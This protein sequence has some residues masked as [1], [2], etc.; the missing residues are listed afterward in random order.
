MFVSVF[1]ASPKPKTQMDHEK[2]TRN[3]H[4]VRNG[5]MQDAQC[6]CISHCDCVC[7][8]HVNISCACSC[9]CVCI[10]VARVNQSLSLHIDVSRT[11]GPNKTKS[12]LNVQQFSFAS[13]QFY[14]YLS[15]YLSLEVTFCPDLSWSAR[16]SWGTRWSH[17]AF[18]VTSPMKP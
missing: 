13:L 11:M 14:S 16:L 3:F 10:C 8:E 4:F 9:A 6:A 12:K 7:V 5:G 17:E 15:N 18:C 1:T 2:K